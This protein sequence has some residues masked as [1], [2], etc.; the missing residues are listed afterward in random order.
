M[1][2][3]YAVPFYAGERDILSFRVK[4]SYNEYGCPWQGELREMEK[5]AEE[6]SQEL[7]SCPYSMVGCKKKLLK[8]NLA[9]HNLAVDHLA[10]AL[11]RIELLNNRVQKLEV[12][13][14]PV[15]FQMQ[16][17]KFL[18]DNCVEWDS[19]PFY[20]HS[21]GY[22]LYIKVYANGLDEAIGSHVSVMVCLMRGEF[23][24]KLKW[25]FRGTI[26]FEL[27]NQESDSDHKEGVARFMERRSSPKN[28]KVTADNGKNNVGWG[29][30]KLLK[31]DDG[32]DDS[33][34]DS[35]DDDSLFDDY[36]I[37]DCLYIRVSQAT[38]S[39]MNKPWLI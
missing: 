12:K 28:R 34:D 25:P 26:S 22:K 11:G 15:V 27:L 19:P 4:C 9:T 10:M 29:V 24:E 6:C 17:F 39:D 21:E 18:R 3:S 36:V 16:R 5:H 13:I 23:D 30:T 32:D 7:I 33:D 35:D 38:V 1:V 20:T 8:K 37:D 14:P 2:G 31:L